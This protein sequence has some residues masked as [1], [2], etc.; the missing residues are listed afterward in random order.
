MQIHWILKK[1]EELTPHQLYAALQLRN[2]VFVVEQN[3]VFQDADD[4]D[5]ASYHLLGCINDKLIAY[6][7]LVPPGVIYDEPSIG[8]V[9]TSPSV[10]GSGAGKMLMQESINKVYDLFGGK[11]IK[12][13]A[14]LYLKKFYEGFGFSQISEAYL[15]DGIPHIYMRRNP[16]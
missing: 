10:R 16:A 7:R 4:K 11:P 12:I 9:V 13:G 14:Q 3:C 2:E 15:E 5:Q 8:R 1:F 6:T